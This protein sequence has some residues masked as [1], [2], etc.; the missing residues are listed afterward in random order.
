M[1]KLHRIEKAHIF[2]NVIILGSADYNEFS[3][4]SLDHLPELFINCQ[5]VFIEQDL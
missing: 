5:R 1:I 3:G 4:Q 2:C